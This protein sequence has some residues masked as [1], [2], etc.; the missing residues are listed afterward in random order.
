MHNDQSLNEKTVQFIHLGDK[1]EN[2]DKT[3]DTTDEIKK[4]NKENTINI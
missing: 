2:I 1:L 4:T 3:K